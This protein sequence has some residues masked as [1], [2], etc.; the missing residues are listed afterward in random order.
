MVHISVF[1][2]VSQCMTQVFH[3]VGMSVPDEGQVNSERAMRPGAVDTQKHTVRDARPARVLGRTV[4]THL[5]THHII[6]LMSHEVRDYSAL[7]GY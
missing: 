2:T 1:L 4:E 7:S 5:T 6:S 3:H